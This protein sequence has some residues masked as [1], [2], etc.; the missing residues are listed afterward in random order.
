MAY[1][2][3]AHYAYICNSIAT[4]IAGVGGDETSANSITL[5][6]LKALITTTYSAVA[7]YDP[8]NWTAAERAVYRG[9]Q[10]RYDIARKFIYQR[11]L[12][13]ARNG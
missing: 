4:Q 13:K 10:R 8:E 1:D 3:N 7:T 2:M 11:D 5:D 6:E 9:R 12:I